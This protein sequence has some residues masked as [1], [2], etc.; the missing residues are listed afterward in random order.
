M[1]ELIC[2]QSIYRRTYKGESQ[3]AGSEGIVVDIDGY[4]A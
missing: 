2:Q 3:P 4:D 1:W